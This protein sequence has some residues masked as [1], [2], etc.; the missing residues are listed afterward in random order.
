M[1]DLGD[2]S[3]R[4]R[5]VMAKADFATKQKLVNLL[6]NSV[7]LHPNKAVVEGNIPVAPSDALVPTH[8]VVPLQRIFVVPR[9]GSIPTI[10]RSYKA[11]VTRAVRRLAE[12]PCPI[13]QRNYYEHILRDEADWD[14]IRRYI[15]ANAK[16]WDE[17]KENPDRAQ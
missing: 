8:H 14:R 16:N 3:A 11:A 13:W 2:V 1:A 7:T 17:D 10:V 5:R 9:V 15:E 4:Y 6:V 12:V